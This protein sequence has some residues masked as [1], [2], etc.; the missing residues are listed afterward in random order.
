MD[1]T[2]Q[3]SLLTEID[4]RQDD[5]LAQLDDLNSRVESMISQ[6]VERVVEP[7]E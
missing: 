3:Q 2:S 1:P 5:L 4:L 6:L 7:A